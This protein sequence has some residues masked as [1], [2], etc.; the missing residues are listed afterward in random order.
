MEDV[1]L[2]SSKYPESIRLVQK[3][4]ARFGTSLVLIARPCGR[5]RPQGFLL[6]VFIF[7]PA[8]SLGTGMDPQQQP[9]G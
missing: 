2:K 3:L 1:Y 5:L 7:S 4:M 9:F 8:C 6:L